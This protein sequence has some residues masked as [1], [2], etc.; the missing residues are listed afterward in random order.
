MSKL[1]EGLL[2][3]LARTSEDQFAKDWA[4]LEKYN[5]IGPEINSF[6][7]QSCELDRFRIDNLISEVTLINN[8]EN[9]DFIPD[10]FYL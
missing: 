1:V 3:Y 5:E 6:I 8:I 10:F 4:E 9:P 7:E 2:A